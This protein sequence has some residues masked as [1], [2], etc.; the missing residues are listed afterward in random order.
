[1]CTWRHKAVGIKT[2]GSILG[3]DEKILVEQGGE[4]L[5][6]KNQKYVWS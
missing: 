6:D 4:M 1:M 5:C 2:L 3:V